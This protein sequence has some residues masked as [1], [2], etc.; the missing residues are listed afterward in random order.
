N[1]SSDRESVVPSAEDLKIPKPTGEP[2]RPGRGGYTLYDALNWSPKAYARFK[3]Y[4]H[5]VIDN[6]LETKLSASA[7][8]PEQFEIVR[9]KAAGEFP[10]LQNYVN[11]WPIDDIILTRLKYMSRCARQ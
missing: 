8:S 7:Q 6:D 4:M 3:K 2:G 9:N 1:S 10:D 5:D 11:L